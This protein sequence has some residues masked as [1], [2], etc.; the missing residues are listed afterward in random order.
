MEMS[1]HVT[2]SFPQYKRKKG[3]TMETTTSVVRPFSLRFAQQPVVQRGDETGGAATDTQT[4]SD[5]IV[6][7][8]SEEDSDVSN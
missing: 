5:G 1:F 7:T 4:S 2:C 8:D 3:S 6:K